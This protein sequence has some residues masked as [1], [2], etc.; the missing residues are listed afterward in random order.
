MNFKMVNVIINEKCSSSDTFPASET[1][2][3]ADLK[4]LIM[5]AVLQFYW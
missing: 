5:N 3:Q 1:R 2:S 4:V